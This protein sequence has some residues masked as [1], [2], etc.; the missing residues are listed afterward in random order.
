MS[1]SSPGHETTAVTHWTC[2]C[3]AAPE[4]EARLHA[5]IDA[6]SELAT[7]ARA[8]E[9]LSYTQQVVNEAL[10]LYPP[11]MAAVAPDY[12]GG[13][14]RRLPGAGPARTCC[15]RLY[16]LHRHPGFWKDRRLS[17]RALAPRRM[18]SVRLCLHPFAAGPA[19]ASEKPSRSKRCSCNC[20]R[21]APLPPTW[22]PTAAAT[23]GTDQP[24]HP[25][26][27]A[28]EVERRLIA[29]ATTLI[30]VIESNRAF[31]ATY[32]SRGEPLTRGVVRR[33]VGAGARDPVSPAAHRARRGDK[34]I[35]FSA[36]T[37]SSSTGFGPRFSRHRARAGGAG[38]QR[39]ASLQAAAH[40][41]PAPAS[42]S[43]TPSAARS[44]ASAA[45]RRRRARVP[46]S[47]GCVRA[48]PGGRLD[49]ISRAA[50]YSARSRTTPPSSS[51]PPAPPASPRR[52]A[53]ARNINRQLARCEPS[54][55]IQRARRQ[56]VVDAAHPRH[57]P[58]RFSP[59]HDRHRVHSH[60]M[61]R[62]CSSA[63]HCCGSRSRPGCAHHLCSPNF[64]YKH[65]L[66]VLGAGGGGTGPSAVR[67]F[68]TAPSRSRELC[69]DS[70]PARA[71][72]A[73]AQRHVPV[74]GLADPRATPRPLVRNAHAQ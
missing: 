71:R 63:A 10:R 39:R 35:L 65:Y 50:A 26:P 2:T 53:H 67:S 7:R 46:C 12:R 8:D 42:P 38:H 33:A 66:K 55:R 29:N 23:R 6:A 15:C 52:G 17:H 70:Y 20:T 32:L 24:A 47:K 57:G 62:N 14:A 30:E 22:V 51:S 9:A 21:S 59:G 19:T 49:D 40:R 73:R 34:L 27:P 11:G 16:L 1:S 58:H 3:C 45:S 37:S 43:C 18:P 69:D 31:R 74:Y 56:P 5:E 28:H 44:S 48:P 36:T 68:S 13:R 61:P 64:G 4:A 72:E 41:A 25:F 60:L 54:G